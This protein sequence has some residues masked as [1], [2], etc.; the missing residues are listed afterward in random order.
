MSVLLGAT[1]R[2]RRMTARQIWKA[3]LMQPAV[4]FQLIILLLHQVD[5]FLCERGAVQVVRGDG[6]AGIA[7]AAGDV[8]RTIGLT[9]ILR[10]HCPCRFSIA[11]ESMWADH[12][13]W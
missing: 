12:R 4:V 5:L 8:S 3:H 2:R 1:D 6:W 11:S 7:C 9:F 10:N 13:E